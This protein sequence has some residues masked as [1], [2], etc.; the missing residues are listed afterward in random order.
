MVGEQA[1]DRLMSVARPFTVS[2]LSVRGYTEI[3]LAAIAGIAA[4]DA[5]HESSGVG[6]L[7][8]RRSMI[9]T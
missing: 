7:A 3:N 1:A 5:R 6:G 8:S 4:F 2:V 9:I